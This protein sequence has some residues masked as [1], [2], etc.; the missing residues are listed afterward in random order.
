V[1]AGRLGWSTDFR[2]SLG[3]AAPRQ[4]RAWAVAHRRLRPAGRNRLTFTL[5]IVSQSFA[6]VAPK[7]LYSENVGLRSMDP[8]ALACRCTG[9]AEFC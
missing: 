8:G 2:P 7:L 5:A 1:T 4:R 6:A 9:G 3:E